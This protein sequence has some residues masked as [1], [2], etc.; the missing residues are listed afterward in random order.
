ME[1]F[2]NTK[3]VCTVLIIGLGYCCNFNSHK[4]AQEKMEIDE[5]DRKNKFDVVKYEKIKAY[6][7]LFGAMIVCKDDEYPVRNYLKNYDRIGE[8]FLK[9]N[10][11]NEFLNLVVNYFETE[12]DKDYSTQ[13]NNLLFIIGKYLEYKENISIEP[14][15]E[16][17]NNVNLTL[18]QL[19]MLENFTICMN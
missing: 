11:F 19:F 8:V 16:N 15:I 9:E 17:F 12:Y 4:M 14:F 6:S 13:A 7:E 1:Y 3:N 5:G 10:D 2:K 18:W